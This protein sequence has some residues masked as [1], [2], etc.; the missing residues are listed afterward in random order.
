MHARK[1]PSWRTVLVPALLVGVAFW[2]AKLWPFDRPP[3]LPARTPTIAD[4]ARKAYEDLSA[5]FRAKI[6]SSDFVGMYERMWDPDDGRPV[7]RSASA[8]DPGGPERPQ[9]RYRVDYPNAKVQADY[10]FDR[11]DDSWQLQSF[12]RRMAGEAGPPRRETTDGAKPP[13]RAAAGHRPG[14][15]D[16]ATP[17]P[18]A[19]TS[20]PSSG[21]PTSPAHEPRY[22][23]IQA[24][25]NLEAI[26]LKFYGTRH[27]WRPIVEANPGLDPRR[28]RPGRKI[29]IPRLAQEATAPRTAHVGTPD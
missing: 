24:G 3:T 2:I 21:T 1:K 9:A 29:L 20:T 17:A 12:L 27:R 7:I 13:T 11:V 5:G 19:G 16:R 14:S 4:D 8:D 25:D 23:V 22:H 28:M 15:R 10:C 6:S 18:R 26:S